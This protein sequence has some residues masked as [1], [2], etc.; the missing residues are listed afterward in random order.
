MAAVKGGCADD[1][2]GGGWGGRL[3][4]LMKIKSLGSL[5]RRG[6]EDGRDSSSH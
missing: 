3:Y 4:P 2:R 6:S 5:R 1:D